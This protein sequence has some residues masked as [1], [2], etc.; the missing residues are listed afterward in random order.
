MWDVWSIHEFRTVRLRFARARSRR[1]TAT[2][3]RLFS[4]RASGYR[5]TRAF[6]QRAVDMLAA[7]KVPDGMPQL[8]YLLESNGRVVGAILVISS[9][10]RT[11]AD[12]NAVRCSLSSWYVEP[13]FRIYAAMLASRALH[14]K[15]P[16]ISIF[17]RLPTRCPRSRCR[18]M[19]AIATAHSSPVLCLRGA[20]PPRPSSRPT[21][22]P[23]CRSKRSNGTCCA[24][25]PHSAASPSGA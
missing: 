21:A 19:C 4:T 18:A 1:P 22:N 16:P 13:Q 10:P 6:W 20:R 14:H 5:R 17:H 8:G 11:G 12:P 9:M 24:I 23:R 25:M 15:A 2:P 7:R 3:W